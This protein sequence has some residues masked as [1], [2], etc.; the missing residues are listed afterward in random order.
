MDTGDPER[1]TAV[2]GIRVRLVSIPRSYVGLP[3]KKIHSVNNFFL[4]L[5]S[6][7]IANCKK[8]RSGLESVKSLDVVQVHKLQKPPR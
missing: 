8:H 1:L 5:I 7:V 4:L 6:R 3:V 2:I